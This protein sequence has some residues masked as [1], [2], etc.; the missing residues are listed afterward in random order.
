MKYYKWT[1]SDNKSVVVIR[2]PRKGVY[3]PYFD[4]NIG[5]GIDMYDDYVSSF[6]DDMHD[7]PQKIKEI[8]EQEAYKI[9]NS[10]NY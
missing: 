8:S 4:K 3:E 6:I 7:N 9:I 1:L 10:K 5:F 2:E